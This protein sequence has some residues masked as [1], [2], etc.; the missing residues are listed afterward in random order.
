MGV[1]TDT[2]RERSGDTSE[3]ERG[4]GW[5]RTEEEKKGC[6]KVGMPVM[7]RR[8]RGG[9]VRLWWAVRVVMKKPRFLVSGG[10]GVVS[11]RASYPR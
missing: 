10:L 1:P 4:S 3:G 6:W 5:R 11:G 8:A 9:G 2:G 7:E